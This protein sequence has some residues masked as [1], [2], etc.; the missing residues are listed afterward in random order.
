[1]R[2]EKL[3]KRRLNKSLLASS[4]SLF[5]TQNK[6]C[7]YNGAIFHPIEYNNKYLEDYFV[8]QLRFVC[9]SFVELS[10]A[11]LLKI[12][13][14]SYHLPTPRYKQNKKS[15]KHLLLYSIRRKLA[16]PY[17]Y[18]VHCEYGKSHQTSQ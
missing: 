13:S 14:R 6:Q 16:L 17:I 8:L 3:Y 7:I 9:T 1:M 5:Y 10:T 11:H 2:R 15:S 12:N 4:N 18:I